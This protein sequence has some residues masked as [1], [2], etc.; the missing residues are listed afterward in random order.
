MV[1]GPV[2][3]QGLGGLALEIPDHGAPAAA[4]HGVGFVGVSEGDDG[5]DI[6]RGVNSE[7][8]LNGTVLLHRRH[9]K[10]DEALP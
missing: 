7:G 3:S 5:M 4:D 8:L 9:G 6:F 1:H 2:P 10:S